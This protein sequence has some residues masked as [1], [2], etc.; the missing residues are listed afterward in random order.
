MIL[1]TDPVRY[2]SEMLPLVKP[3]LSRVLGLADS[4]RVTLL[5]EPVLSNRI[6]DLLVGIWKADP[7]ELVRASS[8]V[9]E[10]SILAV[11]EEEG[12]MEETAVRESLYLH[13]QSADRAIESLEKQ[14]LVNRTGPTRV[15][16]APGAG[17]RHIEIVAVEAKM[18][19]WKQAL[20]QATDYL[21]FADR[22]YVLLDGNQIASTEG[23]ASE[24]A[25]RGIGLLVMHRFVVR[26]LQPAT[27]AKPAPS[28]DRVT[29]ANKLYEARSF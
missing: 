6:P 24:C 8:T 18:R 27:L 9:V 2:E 15:A 20:K 25:A 10:A 19:R 13:Q 1:R 11:L 23:I 16:L 12:E 7:G 17:A 28:R 21:G 22:S 29:A 4:D 14:G 3:S 26:Q 5:E